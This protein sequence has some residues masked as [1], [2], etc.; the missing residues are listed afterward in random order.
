MDPQ[1][2]RSRLE[3]NFI[4]LLEETQQM[5]NGNKQKDW[6]FEKWMEDRNLI[7]LYGSQTGTAQEVAE[8]IGRESRRYYFIPRVASMDDFPVEELTK[9]SLAVFVASTTGQG[10]DPDNMKTFFRTLWSQ[11]KYKQLLSNLK[12]G[13]L[14]LGDSSYQKF[15]YVAKRLN[16]LLTLLGG[17]PILK[18]G[19]GDDQ[20]D[21]G[22]DYVIDPWLN[23]WWNKVLELYPLPE[24]REPLN[25]CV[26]LPSKYKVRLVG[27]EDRNCI[28]EDK[29]M[30]DPQDE[31]SAINPFLAEVTMNKR[32]TSPDHFQEV[33]LLEFDVKCMRTKHK[34]GD[35]LVVQPQNLE[36]HVDEFINVLGLNPE[37][38]F[39]ID[40]NDPNSS[41]PP[42]SLLTRPCTIRECVL[43]YLDIQAIPKR[44][45]FELL[46]FFTK[47]E[48]EREKFKEFASAEG[49]QELYDYC[50]RPKRSI[51]EVLA[52]FPHTKNNIPLD[53]LFDLIPPIKPRSYSIASSNLA[54]PNRVQLLVAVVQYHTIL[55]RP[56]LG[57]C[58]NW[59]SRQSVGNLVPVWIKAGTLTFP[60][61]S[62]EVIPPVLMIGPGTGCAPFRAY[63]QERVASGYHKNVVLIFGCRNKDKDY[64]FKEEWE[65]LVEEQKLKLFCAFSRDQ[66]EKVYVQ[67]RIR[68]NA[69]DLWTLI[70]NHRAMIYF[71]GNAKRVP[72]DVYEALTYL[73][74]KGRG[75]GKEDAEAYMKKNVEKRYQTE[76]WA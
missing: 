64:F 32:V 25:T 74:E 8:R 55:K 21:L 23:N 75:Q 52:D 10:D 66:E 63:I 34:P 13:V 15:N 76:T 16:N 18:I 36:E 42:I 29:Y 59:L 71:A 38:M 50:N 62:S 72:I 60:P 1:I 12:F 6:T 41:L 54:I 31:A 53:Y 4:R 7:I 65:T 44:Y 70:E 45:F 24:G 3:I 14:G 51:M 27:S 47:D 37:Q 73:C 39:Y 2:S 26:L 68:E 48:T 49:Q 33:R 28:I 35:V 67:H 69:S 19:L 56:R 58:T 40:S 20:H 46:S 30:P 9:T 43:R 17:M 57:L 11:R 5:A 22:P 61:L